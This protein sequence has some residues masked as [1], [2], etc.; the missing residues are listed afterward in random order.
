[1]EFQFQQSFTK[2]WNQLTKLQHLV[3]L[4]YKHF[5]NKQPTNKQSFAIQLSPLKS[6]AKQ[7]LNQSGMYLQ[8]NK[9]FTSAS[10][11]NTLTSK[12]TSLSFG[13]P[14]I[15]NLQKACETCNRFWTIINK[16]LK[17]KT[18]SYDHAI[19]STWTYAST[20]SFSFA[21]S[22]SQLL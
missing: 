14:T 11:S 19:A 5:S 8:Q 21:Y 4:I 10:N 22:P 15:H 6:K 7:S 18:L 12:T 13:H 3:Q 16:P 20:K 2:D 17:L 9:T 1:M